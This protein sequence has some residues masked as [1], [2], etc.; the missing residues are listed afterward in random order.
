MDM[1]ACIFGIV[2]VGSVVKV[3][4]TAILAKT[5]AYDSNV[6]NRAVLER[7][8]KLEKRMNNLETIVLEA[9]KHKQFD[10]AL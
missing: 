6:Q 7:L 4:R 3:L 9:E 1:W 10:R 5:R 2:L 8:D